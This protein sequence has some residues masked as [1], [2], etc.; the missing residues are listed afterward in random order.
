M[1]IKNPTLARGLARLTPGPSVATQKLLI[2]LAILGIFWVVLALAT[3]RF[4]SFENMTNVMRQVA[5][6]A[7]IPPTLNTSPLPE[8][9][10]DQLDYGMTIGI[11]LTPKGRLW[12]CWVAGGDSPNRRT[13]RPA[14]GTRRQRRR[15]SARSRCG[16]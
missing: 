12:A 5:D 15:L 13:D 2:N 8:Y 9:D 14:A 10:Y 7:L 4:A 11:E 16:A 6:L 3:S 1:P